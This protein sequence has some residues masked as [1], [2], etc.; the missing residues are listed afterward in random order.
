VR[1]RPDDARKIFEET[2]GNT[3]EAAR[4]ASVPRSTMRDLLRAAGVRGDD[5]FQNVPTTPSP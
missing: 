1:L 2:G 5:A 4:R 3:S